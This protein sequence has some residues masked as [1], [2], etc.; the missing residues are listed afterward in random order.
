MRDLLSGTLNATKSSTLVNNA[1]EEVGV[2]KA[3]IKHDNPYI[4]YSFERTVNTL[5][6]CKTCIRTRTN[7]TG[8]RLNVLETITI[9]TGLFRVDKINLFSNFNKNICGKIH[10]F[11][12]I[13]KITKSD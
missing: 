9:N 2:R 13:S 4:N 3:G 6:A 7:V 10:V 12:R 1:S 8:L 5:S 11:R